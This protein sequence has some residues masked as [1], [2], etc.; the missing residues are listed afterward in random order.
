MAGLR[1]KM[2]NILS[3]AGGV[4]HIH[5]FAP[6]EFRREAEF[7][8]VRAP[9]SG[10]SFR[11]RRPPPLPADGRS[12]AGAGRLPRTRGDVRDLRSW[13]GAGAPFTPGE[14]RPSPLRSMANPKR[15]IDR[16]TRPQLSRKVGSPKSS[17]RR[18]GTTDLWRKM[19][20]AESSFFESPPIVSEFSAKG[21]AKISSPASG[22]EKK[23]RPLDNGATR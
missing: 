4:R 3:A 11:S 16:A 2:C 14:R 8:R 7:F 23:R 15:A 13:P 9:I 18:G 10:I 1:S 19:H 17:G 12:N 22:R 20:L 5:E 21:P 6:T